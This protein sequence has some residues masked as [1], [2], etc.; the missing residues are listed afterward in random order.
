MTRN[1]LEVKMNLTTAGPADRG[2]EISEV[3]GDQTEHVQ[4]LQEMSLEETEHSDFSENGE[5]SNHSDKSDSYTSNNRYSMWSYRTA[6]RQLSCNSNQNLR[7]SCHISTENPAYGLLRL[8]S[9]ENMFSNLESGSSKSGP[10]SFSFC[11]DVSSDTKSVNFQTLNLLSVND[12]ATKTLP[13]SQCVIREEGSTNRV[14]ERYSTKLLKATECGNGKDVYKGNQISIIGSDPSTQEKTFRESRTKE[15]VE[16]GVK[17]LVRCHDQLENKFSSFV[18]LGKSNTPRGSKP[19]MVKCTELPTTQF[20]SSLC[21]NS[22]K[23]NFDPVKPRLYKKHVIARKSRYIR[24]QD[25]VKGMGNDKEKMVYKRVEKRRSYLDESDVR[26]SSINIVAS[27]AHSDQSK[28]LEESNASLD[29]KFCDIGSGCQSSL[30]EGNQNNASKSP[31]QVQLNDREVIVN[32]LSE[33]T[34]IGLHLKDFQNTPIYPLNVYTLLE[35]AT[36]DKPVTVPMVIMQYTRL[37]L[38]LDKEPPFHQSSLQLGTLVTALYKESD[39][40]FVQTPHGVEGFI[41]S[42]DCMPLG[43]LS[44]KETTKSHPWEVVNVKDK[45]HHEVCLV[46]IPKE[47]K[48]NNYRAHAKSKSSPGDIH[49]LDTKDHISETF[50]GVKTLALNTSLV[51]SAETLNHQKQTSENSGHKLH[52]KEKNCS[53]SG[54]GSILQDLCW[55]NDNPCLLSRKEGP[56]LRAIQNYTSRGR[57]ILT[58]KAGDVLTLLNNDIKDWLWVRSTTGNEGFVPKACTA[59]IGKL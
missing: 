17:S 58:I 1:P 45:P 46:T 40:F 53:N 16:N 24:S 56:R 48:P 30:Q 8:Y 49:S 23:T 52:S 54:E 10:S 57:N 19:V 47:N 20:N 43:A 4:D 22:S 9:A 11:C 7:D 29:N 27:V 26:Q 6:S 2:G 51:P 44:A 37:H 12:N 18:N 35:T 3:F 15:W 36:K 32:K 39:W 25:K 41:H 28:S 42:T 14:S 38:H 21:K 50:V 59:E 33:T 31:H 5:P 34:S 55:R 13:S